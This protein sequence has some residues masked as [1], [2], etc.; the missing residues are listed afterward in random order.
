MNAKAMMWFLAGMLMSMVVSAG[1][2][3]AV[4]DSVTDFSGAASLDG[5]S[6]S[7]SLKQARSNGPV[8]VYFFPSAFTRGCDLEAH[9]FAEKADAFAAVD[10]TIVGVSADSI[11]RL[12]DFSSDPEFCAGKFA[13]VSDPEGNIASGFG[14]QMMEP[15]SGM[16]DSRGEVITHGFL[17]RTTFVLDR[18][19]KV[20]ARFSSREDG[21][22]PVEHVSRSLEIVRQLQNASAN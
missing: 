4:G 16:K 10:A 2:G 6:H 20:V 14:L 7:F 15:R 12:N 21:L 18:H 3:V 19:G 13:V 5:K 9:A 22:S 11:E 17:P 8:V 1:S